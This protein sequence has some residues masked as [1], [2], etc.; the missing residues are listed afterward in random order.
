MPPRDQPIPTET[1]VIFVNTALGHATVNALTLRQHLART[2][3]TALASAGRCVLNNSFALKPPA[4][5]AKQ[6]P[7]N[8]NQQN[9]AQT[10]A[11]IIASPRPHIITA[12][13]KQK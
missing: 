9:K 4:T 13:A 12:A 1:W 5:P 2:N 7:E 11:A 6:Q 3:A 8:H 10:A